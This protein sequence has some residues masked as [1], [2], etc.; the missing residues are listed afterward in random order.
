MKTTNQPHENQEQKIQEQQDFLNV[1][2]SLSDRDPDEKKEDDADEA[3]MEDW[4]EV[5]P[6]SGPAPTSPGS[7]V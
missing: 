1:D 4:G 3:T 7:A 5:D 2:Q 6:G